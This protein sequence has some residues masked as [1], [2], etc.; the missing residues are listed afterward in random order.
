MRVS[1]TQ[2]AYEFAYEFVHK[3]KTKEEIRAQ[4]LNRERNLCT[5]LNKPT[6]LHQD[7]HSKTSSFDN[8]M[9]S[10]KINLS[11][12]YQSFQATIV[13]VRIIHH[14]SVSYVCLYSKF[15]L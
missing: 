2:Y 9:A 4:I 7:G 6:R 15:S 10:L 12:L 14:L 5:N 8:Y 11:R 1:C 3:F 13:F